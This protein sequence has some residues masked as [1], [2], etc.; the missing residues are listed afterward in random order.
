MVP[1]VTLEVK[2]MVCP[3]VGEDG[4]KVKSADNGKDA[5]TIV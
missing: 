1:P 4:A 2:E 5:T 3:M